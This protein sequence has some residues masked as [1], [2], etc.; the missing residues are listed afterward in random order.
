VLRRDLTFTPRRWHG[1]V[2]PNS[3]DHLVAAK[4]ERNGARS[5]RPVGSEFNRGPGPSNGRFSG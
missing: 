4:P 5:R 2:T 3:D 1:A